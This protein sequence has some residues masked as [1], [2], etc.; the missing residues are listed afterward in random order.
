M[1]EETD[2]AETLTKEEIEV[3]EKELVELMQKEEELKSMF[4]PDTKIFTLNQRIQLVQTYRKG[5]IE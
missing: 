5:G 1:S 3:Y 4:G 2:F